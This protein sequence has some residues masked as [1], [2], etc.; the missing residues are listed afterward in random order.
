MGEPNQTCGDLIASDLRAGSEQPGL[1]DTPEPDVTETPQ[2]RDPLAD[3][4][5]NVF[6]ELDSGRIVITVSDMPQP[7]DVPYEAQLTMWPGD[8]VSLGY[9][10]P[11]PQ[12]NASLEFFV[13]FDDTH[14]AP[15]EY[16]YSL[17]FAYVHLDQCEKGVPWL[18]KSLEIDLSAANPA[19]QGLAECNE[20]SREELPAGVF[21][22]EEEGEFQGQATTE[23]EEESENPPEEQPQPEG[24][25]TPE[26]Q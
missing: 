6:F 4:R 8:T 13:N 7:E 14:P 16:Y 15:I 11:D 25:N 1:P 22:D 23:S 18:L 10:Q 9:F 2:P 21:Q 3:A 20:I 24:E 12:G 19:W 26:A 17:G 5:G